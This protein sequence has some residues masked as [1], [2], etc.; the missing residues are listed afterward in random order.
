M[1]D[2]TAE[3][4]ALVLT[5]LPK[6]SMFGRRWRDSRLE[7]F[8][9]GLAVTAPA[10]PPRIYHYATTSVLQNLISVNG[11]LVEAAYTLIDTDGRALTIGIGNHSVLG[12]TL[13]R[14]GAREVVRGPMFTEAQKWGPEIQSRV[15]NARF[16]AD[17][18]RIRAG[19]RLAFGDIAFDATSVTVGRRTAE[20]ASIGR[21][22]A[23]DALVRFDDLRNRTCLP[24]VPAHEVP[25]LYEVL[26]LADRLRSQ[27]SI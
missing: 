7:L 22:W 20:W 17:A 15:T 2:R 19:E 4:G 10:E 11:L 24:T 26:A 21:V 18:A 12:R 23:A 27:P 16:P 1:D 13:R 8:A 5:A 6:K 25:N 9:D 3:L 14:L